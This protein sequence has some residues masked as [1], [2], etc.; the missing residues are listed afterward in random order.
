ML[1]AGDAVERRQ[2]SMRAR[3]KECACSCIW[4]YQ[5]ALHQHSPCFSRHASSE[6]TMSP[7]CSLA[8][9][10]KKPLNF[11]VAATWRIRTSGG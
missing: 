3:P 4:T 2:V 9:A 1:L 5:Q 10:Q 6:L 11:V 7:N 8:A